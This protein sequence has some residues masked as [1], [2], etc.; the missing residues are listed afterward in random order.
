MPILDN[1]FVSQV[2]DDEGA[3]NN[4]NNIHE[5][6]LNRLLDEVRWVC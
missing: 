1:D 4:D 2:S 3:V 5:E 6:D